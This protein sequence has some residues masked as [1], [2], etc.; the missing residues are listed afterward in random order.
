MTLWPSH[1]TWERA[2][3]DMTTPGYRLDIGVSMSLSA[4]HCHVNGETALPCDVPQKRVRTPRY[5]AFGEQLERWRGNR[6]I[7]TVVRLVRQMGV[8]FDAATLR[9][10]EYGWTG[11]PDPVAFLSVCRLYGVPVEDAVQALSEARAGRRVALP[12]ALPAEAG[13]G[14]S[15]EERHCL[16]NYRRLS[17]Q[18]R[19]LLT[20]TLERLASPAS[21][22]RPDSRGIRSD[23]TDTESGQTVRKA[24]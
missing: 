2:I 17:P 11:R 6:D 20:T 7:E 4:G 19:R 3:V 22:E 1:G 18:D 10:W 15:D 12:P 14:W 23:E 13:T 8:P 24:G 9:G 16:E 21:S 5:R